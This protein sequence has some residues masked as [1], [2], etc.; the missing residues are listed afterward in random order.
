MELSPILANTIW[1]GSFPYSFK[2]FGLHVVAELPLEVYVIWRL[3][4]RRERFG[5][6]FGRVLLANIASFLVGTLALVGFSVPTHSLEGT[7]AAWLGAFL[8]S[9]LVEALLLGRW[10]RTV[11]RPTTWRASF[12]GNVASY[13]IASLVFVAWLRGVHI[14][15][16]MLPR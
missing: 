15:W 13:T 16:P 11:S 4:Q 7:A 3:I 12:W 8:I 10:M 1:V 14:P 6:L 9:W 5:W 2:F